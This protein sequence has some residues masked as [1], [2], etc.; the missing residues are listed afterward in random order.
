MLL[1]VGQI[2]NEVTHCEIEIKSKVTVVKKTFRD[3]QTLVKI[4]IT[5]HI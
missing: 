5:T 4:I 2:I 3:K 1:F